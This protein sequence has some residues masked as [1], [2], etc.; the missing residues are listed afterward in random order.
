MWKKREIGDRRRY[1]VNLKDAALQLCTCTW[2]E[3]MT[4]VGVTMYLLHLGNYN[5]AAI[6]AGLFAPLIGFH[7]V[8]DRLGSDGQSGRKLIRIRR[9]TSAPR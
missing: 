3:I 7:F 9:L 8:I 4:G 2:I 5:L 6:A 1:D